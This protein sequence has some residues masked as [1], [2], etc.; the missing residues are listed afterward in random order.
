M[1]MNLHTLKLCNFGF[2]QS[3]YSGERMQTSASAT[4]TS[5]QSIVQ[6]VSMTCFMISVCFWYALEAIRSEVEFLC[7]CV[8]LCVVFS[9][10]PPPPPPQVGTATGKDGM[11]WQGM[12]QMTFF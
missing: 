5:H 7:T 2:E 11:T 1:Y 9:A 3:A 8:C 6:S 12:T 4:Q 10:C